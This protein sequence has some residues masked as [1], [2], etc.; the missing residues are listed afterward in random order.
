LL[1]PYSGLSF[2][3]PHFETILLFILV[4][5]PGSITVGSDFDFLVLIRLSRFPPIIRAGRE[6][7]KRPVFT[8]NTP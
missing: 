6:R 8:K 2:I 4:P 7:G 3:V 5:E 1:V